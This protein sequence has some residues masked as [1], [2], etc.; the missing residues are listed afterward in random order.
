MLPLWKVGQIQK[1]RLV[2]GTRKRMGACM[3]LLENFS[4]THRLVSSTSY[5]HLE[6]L[7]RYK[8]LGR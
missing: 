4:K 1:L 8:A 5:S 6:P 3:G 7:L 2:L